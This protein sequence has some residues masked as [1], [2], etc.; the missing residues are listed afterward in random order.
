MRIL[1]LLSI[2]TAVLSC[3]IECRNSCLKLE[4]QSVCDRMCGCTSGFYEEMFSSEGK[5]YRIQTVPEDEELLVKQQLGCNVRELK[6]CLEY[7]ESGIKKLECVNQEG[8]QS[9]LISNA[10]RTALY[11]SACEMYCYDICTPVPDSQACNSICLARLCALSSIN[12]V[13]VQTSQTENGLSMKMILVNMVILTSGVSALYLT[14]KQLS[15]RRNTY[16]KQD[17]FFALE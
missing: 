13:Q 2:F 10:P 5:Q 17:M 11:S 14:V 1:F 4:S 15:K 12:T 9:L 7:A 6:N 3:S 16:E 8:C